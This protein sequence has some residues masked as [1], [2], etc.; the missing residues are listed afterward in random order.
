M[1]IVLPTSLQAD[2]RVLR[3]AGWS[4]WSRLLMTPVLLLLACIAIAC[5][6]LYA[7][8]GWCIAAS[9]VLAFAGGQALTRGGLTN[10]L[11]RARFGWCAALP[12]DPRV[13][14]RMM[15]GLAGAALLT[16]IVAGTLL[17]GL[18][19]IAAPYREAL[20]L[21]AFGLDGGLVIGTLVAVWLVLRKDGIVRM[22]HADGIREPLLALPWLNDA[23]LPHLLDWQRRATLV[24]WRRGGGA[25]MA[26]LAM[27]AVP[28]GESVP[29]G[30]G[31]ILLV[32]SL[33]WLDVALRASAKAAADAA[34]LLQTISL[35]GGRLR[36]ASFRYPLLAV[37]C[38]VVL[39]VAGAVLVGDKSV[40][41]GL[42]GAACTIAVSA[43][44]LRRVMAA[45][46]SSR[47]PS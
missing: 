29:R 21:A 12:A 6:T 31:L 35:D 9:G 13:T 41:A 15:L 47:R 16:A 42:S 46:R 23:R 36:I 4:A 32:I 20:G 8:F 19:A 17:L 43:W 22:R 1:A 5:G 40:L 2:L 38:T 7:G 3:H 37:V 25:A 24:N 10:V 26:A 27:F 45:T 28:N 39:T 11:T 33:T 30:A 18:A 34:L 14:T 44:P